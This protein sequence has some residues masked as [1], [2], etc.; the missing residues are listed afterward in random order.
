MRLAAVAGREGTDEE[1]VRDFRATGDQTCF[2]TLFERHRR[3]V[4]GACRGFFHDGD[5]AEDATQETFLHAFRNLDRFAGGDFAGWIMRIA[6][7][8][9][10]DQW[11]RQ[12][13]EVGLDSVT[14]AARSIGPA[15]ERSTGLRLVTDQVWEQMKQLPDKQ[16]QCLELII[17]G[18]SYREMAALT[19]LSVDAVKSNIQNGRRMLWQKLGKTL[20]EWK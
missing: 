1:L 4:Y 17:D 20:T 18:H 19:C 14:D 13:H 3:K 12:R 5:A 15:L 9:C 6:K 16:R 7:N 11:R 10:I 8:V 2:L